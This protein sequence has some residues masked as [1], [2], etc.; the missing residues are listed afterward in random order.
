MAN[1]QLTSTEDIIEA[2]AADVQAAWTDCVDKVHVGGMVR[3]D[4]DIPY[5]V[6]NLD[7][8]EMVPMSLRTVRQIHRFSITRV[9]AA[10][11]GAR[12][13]TE[14]ITKV[15]LLLAQLMA[16][17]TYATYG[18]SPLANQVLMDAYPESIRDTQYAITVVFEVSVEADTIGAV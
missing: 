15:N 16:S 17:A 5:A 11:A 4:R 9:A 2:I 18:F 3:E 6:V 8:V 12:L 14:K 1:S 7:Q 13:V 10:T